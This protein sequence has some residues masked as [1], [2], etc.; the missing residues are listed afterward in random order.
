M[1]LGIKQGFNLIGSMT[2][3]QPGVFETLKIFS[4]VNVKFLSSKT[5]S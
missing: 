1:A 4:R 2:L 5:L 3:H